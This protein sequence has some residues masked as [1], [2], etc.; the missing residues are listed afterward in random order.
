MAY[1]GEESTDVRIDDWSLRLEGD[2]YL[3]Q[4]N[5]RELALDLAFEAREPPL[6]QGH[7]GFSRKGPRPGQASYYYS[8]PQLAVSGT[9]RAGGAC[10]RR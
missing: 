3:A 9:L 5:S 10:V 7:G 2:R 6:L 4:I 1:A 8:R